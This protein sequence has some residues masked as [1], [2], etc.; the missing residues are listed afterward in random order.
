MKI[1]IRADH[2]I[3]RLVVFYFQDSFV[4]SKIFDRSKNLD[5]SLTS[6]IY[7]EMEETQTSPVPSTVNTGIGPEWSHL[8]QASLANQQGAPQGIVHQTFM[9]GFER[10]V[11][12]VNVNLPPCP[13]CRVLFSLIHPPFGFCY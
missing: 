11:E 12:G 1:I 9:N 2:L 8:M 10:H 13:F 4:L 7:E 5:G 3:L 6:G